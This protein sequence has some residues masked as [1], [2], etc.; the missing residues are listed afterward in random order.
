MGRRIVNVDVRGMTPEI[1]LR[2]CVDGDR[3]VIG[4][5]NWKIA[6]LLV[7]RDGSDGGRME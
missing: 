2:S 3:L 7:F 6:R 1:G 4:H 5:G